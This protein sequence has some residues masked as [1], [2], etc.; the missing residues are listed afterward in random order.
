MVNASHM[1]PRKLYWLPRTNMTNY[2]KLEGLNQQT[3]IYSHI[4][5]RAQTMKPS[6]VSL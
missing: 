5:F 4:D 1:V 3:K 6:C 2:H